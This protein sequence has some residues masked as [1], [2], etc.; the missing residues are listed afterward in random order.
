MKTEKVQDRHQ[1]IHPN[2]LVGKFT[3]AA[4]NGHHHE[5]NMNR[6]QRLHKK[7]MTLSQH[8]WSVNVTS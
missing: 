4:L 3:L 2:C 5:R 8:V 7:H 1:S 6:F